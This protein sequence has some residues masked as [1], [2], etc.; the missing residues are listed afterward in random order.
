M[1]TT[2]EGG[3]HA[4]QETT[5]SKQIQYHLWRFLVSECR[6]LDFSFF[7]NLIFNFLFYLCIFNFL[8]FYS[9]GPLHIYYD[10]QFGI[11]V[12]FLSV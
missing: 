1:Q 3:P 6:I 12:G 5:N 10:S 8:F 7:L 11:F 4:Q 9:T 2:L